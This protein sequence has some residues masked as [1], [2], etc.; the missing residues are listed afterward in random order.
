MNDEKQINKIYWCGILSIVIV[1]LI[2]AINYYFIP[3]SLW[4]KD[5]DANINISTEIVNEDVDYIFTLSGIKIKINNE[6]KRPVLGYS[7][8]ISV[9]S[10]V[11]DGKNYYVLLPISWKGQSLNAVHNKML[12]PI[13]RNVTSKV[14]NVDIIRSEYQPVDIS[15][16]EFYKMNGIKRL[17]HEN[18]DT[19]KRVIFSYSDKVTENE[20]YWNKVDSYYYLIS[21]ENGDILFEKT[22]E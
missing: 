7:G 18:L 4:C 2:Y 9:V 1:L 8:R 11:T 19:F 15:N 14:I 6:I 22:E 21:P 5:I 10:T 17:I 16:V 13:R 12:E 20:L 3:V